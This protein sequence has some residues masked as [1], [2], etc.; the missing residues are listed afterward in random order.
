MIAS[1]Q[2]AGDAPRVPRDSNILPHLTQKPHER[3][4][5]IC[6]RNNKEANMPI[7]I[8]VLVGIPVLIGGGYL[9]IHAFH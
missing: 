8:P 1:A 3:L 9:I 5:V 6:V 2:A 7:L 4:C